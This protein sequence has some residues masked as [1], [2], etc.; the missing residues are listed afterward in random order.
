MLLPSPNSSEH[1][2]NQKPRKSPEYRVSAKSNQFYILMRHIASKIFIVEMKVYVR[3]QQ[4]RKSHEYRVLAKSNQFYI[5]IR[6]I[7]SKIFIVEMKVYVRNQQPRKPTST[8]F[9]KHQ[10]EER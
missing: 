2:R 10:D 3:N 9:Y 7:A 8:E 5:L 4:P 1:P 6:H